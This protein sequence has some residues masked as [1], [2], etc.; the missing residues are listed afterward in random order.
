MDNTKEE[1]VVNKDNSK[2][3]KITNIVLFVIEILSSLALIP[4][5]IIKFVHDR[6]AY[7]DGHGG[8]LYNDYYYNLWDNIDDH[9]MILFNILLFVSILFN[10][11]CIIKI[12]KINKKFFIIAHIIFVAVIMVL[13][14]I[15]FFGTQSRL[16]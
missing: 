11:I 4:L 8:W 15:L 2:I 7:P 1:L 6:P 12:N 5:Q 16:Y 3:F 9:Y 14:P 10:I 13:I